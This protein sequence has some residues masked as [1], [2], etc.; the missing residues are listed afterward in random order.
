MLTIV[1]A[2]LGA[3]G[4]VVAVVAYLDA[5]ASKRV[6]RLAWEATP[7]VPLAAA[8]RTETDYKLS[9]LYERSDAKP[10]VIDS[11]DVT[12]VRFANLG[13]EPIR[14][15]D[16][17]PASVFRLEI[18][19]EAEGHGRPL[20]V[21][22][23]ASSREVVQLKIGHLSAAGDIAT[24]SVAFDFLDYQDGGVLRVL[25]NG[26]PDGVRMKGDIVGMPHGL[27]EWNSFQGTSTE[28]K[29]W[30]VA[31]WALAE[32]IAFG[33]LGL[34][35]REVTGGWTGVWLLLLPPVAFVAV[36]IFCLL[37]AGGPSAYKRRRLRFPKSLA[38]P[39][40]F[41]FAA[42]MGPDGE[43]MLRRQRPPPKSSNHGDVKTNTEA[44]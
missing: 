12:Y 6:K 13:K 25:S 10:E 27:Q 43:Y 3:I 17:A 41:G 18:K 26:A 34:L 16:I 11:A 29:G 32:A 23:A 8:S 15:E 44:P 4:S 24:V 21:S 31:G 14:K 9:I 39:S 36:L 38:I 30:G 33:A 40:H 20:D 2:V 1:L 42:M 37:V 35:F 5:R 19:Y 7:S 22:V 28:V